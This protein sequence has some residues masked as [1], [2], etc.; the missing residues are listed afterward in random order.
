M[1]SLFLSRLK[2]L[3]LLV[4]MARDNSIS[5]LQG[6]HVKAKFH[7]LISIY[8]LSLRREFLKVRLYTVIH[9]IKAPYK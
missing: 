8:N 3:F 7:L 5:I 9:L 2:E 4:E 1:R 6:T